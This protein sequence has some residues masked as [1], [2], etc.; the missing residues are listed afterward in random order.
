M[1]IV[2]LEQLLKHWR[3]LFVGVLLVGLWLWSR[4]DEVCLKEHYEQQWMPEGDSRWRAH[5]GY[6][7]QQWVCDSVGK[8]R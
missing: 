6:Y 4:R 3:I 2:L 7:R 1:L 8:K 5:P